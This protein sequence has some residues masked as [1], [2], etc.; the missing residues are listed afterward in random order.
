MGR[1]RQGRSLTS[2]G[3]VSLALAVNNQGGVFT[4]SLGMKVQ[5]LIPHTILFS[6]EML[7]VWL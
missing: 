7:C 2:L 3:I 5:D 4:T 1:E 6:C